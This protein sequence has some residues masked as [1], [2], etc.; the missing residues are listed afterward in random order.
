MWKACNISLKLIKF[1]CYIVQCH[2]SLLEVW[3][4]YGPHFPTMAI[5]TNLRFLLARLTYVYS[6]MT[7]VYVYVCAYVWWPIL[8][9]IRTHAHW[10]VKHTYVFWATKSKCYY[11]WRYIIMYCKT[12]VPICTHMRTCTRHAHA[13]STRTRTR[14]H[15]HL[16]QCIQQFG[17]Q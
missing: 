16:L 2:F 1:R 17:D 4:I 10:I 7:Y 6:C 13:H 8:Y 11:M 15:T 14:T 3:P 5:R 9:S 12:H